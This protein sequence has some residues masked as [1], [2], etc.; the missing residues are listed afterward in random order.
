MRFVSE[1]IGVD[2]VVR[3][4]YEHHTVPKHLANRLF[5]AGE[6]VPAAFGVGDD[7]SLRRDVQ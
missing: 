6:S 3:G 2:R 1:P 7:E 4:E 5:T